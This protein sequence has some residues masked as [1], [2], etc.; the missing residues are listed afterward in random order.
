MYFSVLPATIYAY[1]VSVVPT[2]ATRGCQVYWSN[3]G[4]EP[5]LCC[6]VMNLGPLAEQ[7]VLLTAE[8]S[9]QLC[10]ILL[11]SLTATQSWKTLLA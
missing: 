1:H 7:P 9:L 3:K 2:E 8:P 6:W 10:N 5:P 11:Q 4:C